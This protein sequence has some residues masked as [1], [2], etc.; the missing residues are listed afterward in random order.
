M[1]WLY[2][3]LL[4]MYEQQGLLSID[5]QCCEFI[6]LLCPLWPTKDSSQSADRLAS[7]PRFPLIDLI[8]QNR[9][10]VSCSEPPKRLTHLHSD[11][12]IQPLMHTHVLCRLCHVPSLFIDKFSSTCAQ[13]VH[14][15]CD[16]ASCDSAMCVCVFVNV[17]Y[18]CLC[19]CQP[20]LWCFQACLMPI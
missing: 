13:V 5:G 18:V 6:R 12:N 2:S 8:D 9:T 3:V 14:A 10:C 7:F 17:L 4:S 15:H 11:P 1:T 20:S 16:C 19:K